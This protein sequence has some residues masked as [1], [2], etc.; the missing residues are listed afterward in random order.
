MKQTSTYLPLAFAALSLL[1]A[2]C[3]KAEL[4]VPEPVTDL[5]AYPGLYRAKVEF[6]VPSDAVSAKVFHSSGKYVQTE[7]EDPSAV[8]SVIVEGLSAGENII[9]VVT[10]NSEG[11][12]SDPRGVRVQ[13]YDD[14]YGNS[15]ENRELIEQI[16]GSSNS[17]EMYF[18][19]ALE[20]E[21]ELRIE[22]TGSDGSEKSVSLTP[23]QT[24]VNIEDINLSED[25]I[26]YSVYKPT[27]DFIDEYLTE[28]INA[29]TAAMKNFDK[30]LWQVVG[31]AGAEAVDDDASTAWTAEGAGASIT[32]DMQVEKIYNGFAIVQNGDMNSTTFA[33][34]MTFEASSDNVEW[35]Q[36]SN[37][38]LRL[39]GYRQTYEFEAPVTS[40]YFRITFTET[41]EAGKPVAVAEL[42]LYNELR[43]SG[44][45]GETMPQL[46]NNKFPFETDGSDLF[47][48][49]AAGRFSRVAGWTHEN[50]AY[51]TADL[52]SGSAQ[53]CTWC[54]PVWGCSAVDNGKVFQIIELKPGVYGFKLDIAH[55]T[56]PSGV[57]MYAVIA[58]GTTLPVMDNLSSEEVLAYGD[59]VEHSSSVYTIPFTVTEPCTVAIGLVY[60]LYD[61]YATAGYIWSDMYLNSFEIEAQ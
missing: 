33:S 2:A 27:A 26:Y 54:A 16:I 40:R 5:K 1:A 52:A 50:G 31:G 57:D 18:S 21:V 53:F 43:T 9:R 20:N 36:I 19:D 12:N 56:D 58:K 39:N 22:Y 29:R 37:P 32:V 35:Q 15:L 59:V 38:R 61:V 41:H 13:V 30:E 10:L 17:V 60:S 46:V 42:D 3:Q 48:N 6:S 49:V 11:N 44:D 34:R 45:Q 23:D 4:P 28:P 47:P 55:T 51:I 7:I 8:Q 25:Y 24:F 14:S